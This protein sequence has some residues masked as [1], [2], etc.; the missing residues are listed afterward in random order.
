MAAFALASAYPT[1][2]AY[3]IASV[4]GFRPNEQIMHLCNYALVQQ[5][6]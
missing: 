4:R 1:D 2:Q 6:D 5:D 3:I